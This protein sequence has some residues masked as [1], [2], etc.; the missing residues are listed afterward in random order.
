MSSAILLDTFAHAFGRI[1]AL[2]RR[3]SGAQRVMKYAKIAEK[4]VQIE[5]I[6][7]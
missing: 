3:G 4:N 6:E 1:S 2:G 5:I 7:L